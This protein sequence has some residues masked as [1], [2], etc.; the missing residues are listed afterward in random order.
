MLFILSNPSVETDLKIYCSE[1]LVKQGR[2]NVEMLAEAYQLA[3]FENKEIENAERIYKSLSP[4]RARPL[5]YQSIMRD[6]KP[7]SKLRKIIAL[8]KISI[9]DNLLSKISHLVGGSY[10]FR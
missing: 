4:M 8:I 6:N 7:D 3:K 10:G 5:L 1:I 2:I 9:N